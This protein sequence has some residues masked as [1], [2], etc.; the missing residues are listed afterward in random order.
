M[1][2]HSSITASAAP[3]LLSV[4]IEHVIFRDKEVEVVENNS[5]QPTPFEDTASNV[6]SPLHFLLEDDLGYKYDDD[7]ASE[8]F[9]GLPHT[10]CLL[11]VAAN[12]FGAPYLPN[13]KSVD[14]VENF[15]AKDYR[16]KRY[17]SHLRGNS[18]I[19]YF[20]DGVID[21]KTCVGM[22]RSIATE[23]GYK[24]VYNVAR[25]AGKTI[26]A[27]KKGN[28]P[29]NNSFC[30]EVKNL[31]YGDER[32]RDTTATVKK[33]NSLHPP[34]N[35][36]IFQKMKNPKTKGVSLDWS[37]TAAE[38]DATS[39]RNVA[40]LT[41][42]ICAI[43]IPAYT[44]DEV[45]AL[46]GEPERAILRQHAID[47]SKDT[48]DVVDEMCVLACIK[49]LVQYFSSS[50]K[51]H[52]FSAPLRLPPFDRHPIINLRG[53]KF[54]FPDEKVQNVIAT[55][56]VPAHSTLIVNYRNER[57]GKKI[58]ETTEGITAHILPSMLKQSKKNT[59]KERNAKRDPFIY[60]SKK[61]RP[62]LM[63]NVLILSGNYGWFGLTLGHVTSPDILFAESNYD[64]SFSS[65][66]IRRY[67]NKAIGATPFRNKHLDLRFWGMEIT[68][69]VGYT[70]CFRIRPA[71]LC[72]SNNMFNIPG[73]VN[74]TWTGNV[75]EGSKNPFVTRMG[76]PQWY[77]SKG[78]N[79]IFGEVDLTDHVA[80]LDNTMDKFV[81]LMDGNQRWKVNQKEKVSVLKKCTNLLILRMRHLAKRMDAE[82]GKQLSHEALNQIENDDG[83]A[84][85]S[86]ASY[87]R[88]RKVCNNTESA[89]IAAVQQHYRGEKQKQKM[90]EN[91]DGETL[92][93]LQKAFKHVTDAISVCRMLTDEC[94]NNPERFSD[95]ECRVAANDLYK[96]IYRNSARQYTR[97]CLVRGVK[98][99]VLW[100][101]PYDERADEDLAGVPR[102]RIPQL[103]VGV[104]NMEEK[105]RIEG[106]ELLLPS[107][108][109]LNTRD[110][111][112]KPM[113]HILLSM[114]YGEKFANDIS[115]MNCLE[116]MNWCT[117][118]VG[119]K[120]E[121][122]E[123]A[124]LVRERFLYN[125]NRKRKREE[126]EKD[127]SNSIISEIVY[128]KSM[129]V[130]DIMFPGATSIK[131]TS[132]LEDKASGENKEEKMSEVMWPPKKRIKLHTINKTRTGRLGYKDVYIVALTS[133]P[134]KISKIVNN[135]A[136]NMGFKIPNM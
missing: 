4:L 112:P 114:M 22:L 93:D 61:D 73:K 135:V 104:E 53:S 90:W 2:A 132:K 129:P 34:L 47:V 35:S 18:F 127:A 19:A 121:E 94:Q 70:S 78:L 13:Q 42:L 3:D 130:Y 49:S 77:D 52:L 23:Y 24:S 111:N 67:R 134:Q 120:T 56:S 45:V 98:M 64:G 101:R 39:C 88:R 51:N 76:Y 5:N 14:A 43:I 105:Q 86:L 126:E 87:S 27:E 106:K 6:L 32:S 20:I 55:M 100:R 60:M 62:L 36:E 122:K 97:S 102:C 58:C 40:A 59:K 63:R 54:F 33:P 108:Q 81:K 16:K 75:V 65:G 136:N 10:K 66:T 91:G 84:T 17:L 123:L 133:F 118:T 12:E 9:A 72:N 109:I 79:D 82:F 89:I 110:V 37:E 8:F 71:S 107:L 95:G 85:R 7:H 92:T 103:I 50:T 125:K 1:V 131:R 28:S 21:A 96:Y 99:S 11:K 26:D 44:F 48:K 41:N 83:K 57:K 29:S 116:W 46:N 30:V 25:M 38:I 69:A 74:N 31:F 119:E 68:E 117:K 124:P 80:A 15:W 128:D 113:R 115:A